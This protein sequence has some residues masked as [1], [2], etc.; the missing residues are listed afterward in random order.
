MRTGKL[1]KLTLTDR[2]IKLVKELLLAQLAAYMI[3]EFL[4]QSIYYVF[5][6]EVLPF[7][8]CC[9]SGWHTLKKIFFK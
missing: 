5:F 6:L 7:Q 3:T 2:R 9:L 1:A 8:Q 4:R